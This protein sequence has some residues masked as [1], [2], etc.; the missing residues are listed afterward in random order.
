MSWEHFSL[1][2]RKIVKVTWS[3][4]SPKDIFNGLPYPLTWSNGFCAGSGKRCALVGKR[5]CPWQRSVCHNKEIMKKK[6][7][8]RRWRQENGQTWFFNFFSFN[9]TLFGH[10]LKNIAH[11]FFGAWSLLLVH[12]RCTPSERSKGFVNWYL[13]KLEHGSWT[14]ESDHGKTPS[15]MVRLHNPWCTPTLNTF[16][17]NQCML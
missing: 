8:K 14:F 6:M 7:E 4:R 16:Q 10:M 5:R 13:K 17:E 11:S 15:S 1:H 12:I 2:Q 9:T 3:L